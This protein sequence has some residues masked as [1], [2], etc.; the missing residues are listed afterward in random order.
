MRHK[1]VSIPINRCDKGYA[2]PES[3]TRLRRD[4]GEMSP[5]VLKKVHVASF[6]SKISWF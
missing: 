2:L 3:M 4:L 6:E 1:F 5:S